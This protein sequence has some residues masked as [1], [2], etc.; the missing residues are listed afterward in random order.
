MPDLSEIVAG[1]L[2]VQAQRCAAL[3]S[4]FYADLLESAAADFEAGG[5][6]SDVVAGF[7]DDPESSA[8]ALRL[9]GAVHRLVLQ[10]RLPQLT[11]RYPSVGGDGDA[12]MAWPSFRDA[13]TEHRA[14]IRRL[15]ARGCQTNEVG[16]SAALLGGFL[17]IAHRTRLP[18][19]ILEIGASAGLNLRWDCYRYE[20]GQTGWGDEH[21]PVRFVHFFDVP[22]TLDRTAE[23]IERKGCDLEPIDA[24]SDDGALSLRSFIWADQLGRLSRLDGAIEVAK[25][26]PV[27]VER[28]DA[29]AFLEREL[30]APWPDAAT[31]VFHSVFLQYPTEEIRSR[32]GSVI[33]AA[34]SR[35]TPDAPVFHLSMEP[36]GGRFEI[37]L[38][39]ELLGTSMAHGT[40]VRWLA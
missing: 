27:D 6:V 17:E 12:A 22:P 40:G 28:V 33:G 18:L 14:E 4:P 37:R 26:M 13:L 10:D 25:Q 5:P 1:A 11:S 23:V 38:D 31:V 32:I 24:T 35:A 19:R 16:R 30:D 34:V 15:M 29:V 9:L 36:D 3:G 39:D 21:S 8:L 7:D 20:S 2:R